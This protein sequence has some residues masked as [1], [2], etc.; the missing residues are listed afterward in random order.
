MDVITPTP[1]PRTRRGTPLL[2]AVALA[3]VV[4]GAAVAAYIFTS[5]RTTPPPTTALGETASLT[6]TGELQLDDLAPGWTIGAP[7]HAL[8]TGYAD[9]AEGAQIK[10]TNPGGTIIA[11]AKLGPG[12]VAAHP[13]LDTAK[14]CA[15]PIRITGVPT[16]HGIYGIE[17][18]RRGAVQFQEADLVKPVVL[19]LG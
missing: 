17:V 13:T 14:I 7:C 5:D 12:K 6:I 16:G 3:V 2:A 18:S 10:V 9:V 1:P 15:F 19:T 8:S 4:A 11:T